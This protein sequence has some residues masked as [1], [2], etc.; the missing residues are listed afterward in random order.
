MRLSRRSLLGGLA[1]TACLGCSSSGS[2]SASTTGRDTEEEEL[3]G[4]APVAGSGFG[5]LVELGSI[6]DVIAAIDDGDGF[7]YYPEACSYV[8][9][10]PESSL[11]AA[12]E[13]YD[14]SELDGLAA[15][16][17]AL[18]Q[19]C[20]HLGCRVPQCTQ[21][22]RFECPC[23][24]SVF[25]S[26]GEHVAGPAG[27]GMDRFAVLV[28]DDRLLLD[29]G[30]VLEGLD[31]GVVTA[32]LE[33]T[34]PACVPPS[35]YSPPGWARASSI[36]RVSIEKWART[37]LPSRIVHR[38]TSAMSKGVPV[39]TTVPFVRPTWS[40]SPSASNIASVVTAESM[41]PVRAPANSRKPAWPSCRPPHGSRSSWVMTTASST[42]P[43]MVAMSLAAIAS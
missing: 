5:G 16:F 11:D 36:A 35:G 34:G 31:I 30:T 23:H 10:Y 1:A 2:P 26:M 13:V 24:A 4:P 7:A 33:P 17:V 41:A 9:R 39:P 27:R 40:T 37:P 18:H 29:T 32:D 19:K 8:V 28:D 43:A 3:L 22:G 12:G 42:S 15:G 20:P 25:S 6:D 21:S 38:C 14:G